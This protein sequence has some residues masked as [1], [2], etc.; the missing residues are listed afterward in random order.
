MIHIALIIPKN[1]RKPSK[2][3]TNALLSTL[4]HS[5]SASTILQAKQTYARQSQS[6]LFHSAAKTRATE[7]RSLKYDLQ[8]KQEEMAKDRR[9]KW[10]RQNKDAGHYRPSGARMRSP[11]NAHFF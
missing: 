9:R 10:Q 2:K 5:V 3:I 7:K 6:K 11:N 8:K 1:G 4:L